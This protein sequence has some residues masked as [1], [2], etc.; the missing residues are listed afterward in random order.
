VCPKKSEI[1]PKTHLPRVFKKG[2]Q[3][4][5]GRGGPAGI[6]AKIS[7]L[8]NEIKIARKWKNVHKK[9]CRTGKKNFTD[10]SVLI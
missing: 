2:S 5:K 7:N 9:K 10:L 6:D 3:K 1:D 4:E 8:S